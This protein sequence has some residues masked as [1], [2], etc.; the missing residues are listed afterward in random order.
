MSRQIKHRHKRIPCWVGNLP[1]K[2][3]AYI[4]LAQDW[5]HQHENW[6]VIFGSYLTDCIDNSRWGMHSFS[7]H[8]W[9]MGNAPQWI[10]STFE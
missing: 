6:S 10:C 3:I 2:K 1:R 4:Y 7:L 5:I 9:D 8:F